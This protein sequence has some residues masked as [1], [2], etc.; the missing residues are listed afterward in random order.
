MAETCNRKKR[1]ARVDIS[2]GRVTIGNMASM[3]FAEALRRAI[4]D[5]GLPYLTLEQ[6]TG[7]HRASISRFM[8]GQ[9]TLRL[10]VADQLAA[11]F[12]LKVIPSKPEPKG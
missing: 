10:N 8:A 2:L 1:R 5:S 6:K 9:R 11:F 4:R 7:V 12:G 3:P